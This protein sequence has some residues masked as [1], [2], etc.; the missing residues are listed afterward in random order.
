MPHRLIMM[1]ESQA[2]KIRVMIDQVQSSLPEGRFQPL[3][4][5]YVWPKSDSCIVGR[6]WGRY[7]RR[8]LGLVS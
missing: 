5:S 1:Q 4:Q 8:I 6:R 3:R 7:S 2:W